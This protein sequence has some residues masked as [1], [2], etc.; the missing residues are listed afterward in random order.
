MR[1]RVQVVPRA[2]RRAIEELPGGDLKVWV[3][4]PPVRGQ[5]NR[6][7]IEVLAWHF[8]VSERRVRLISGQTS[9]KKVFEV[10]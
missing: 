1:V 10:D 2:S 5:A 6:A 8:G 3:T 9:R 4:A 7:V